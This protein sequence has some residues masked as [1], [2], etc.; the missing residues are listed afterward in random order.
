MT[1]HFR[2]LVHERKANAG[3]EDGP[4]LQKEGVREDL[5]NRDVLIGEQV[6]V[7]IPVGNVEKVEKVE[8]A[9]IVDDLGNYRRVESFLANLG[10]VRHRHLLA[11]GQGVVEKEDV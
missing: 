10:V 1:A 8:V 2:R 7:V 6:V 5:T 3:P 4:Y 11:L 9:V